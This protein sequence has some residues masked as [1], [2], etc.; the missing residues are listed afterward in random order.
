[1][2]SAA[3]YECVYG[4]WHVP[5]IEIPGGHGFRRICGFDDNRLAE[6]C[7]EF[8]AGKHERPFFLVAS[9]D[10]PHNICGWGH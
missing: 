1:V 7:A 8:I 10:N 5:E 2:L 6:R 3:G 9:F 4:K